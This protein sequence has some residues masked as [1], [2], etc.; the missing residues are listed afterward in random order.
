[1]TAAGE[2]GAA[3]VVS[4]EHPDVRLVD[5]TKK[6]DDVVAVDGLSLEIE[7]G[8]FFAMLG[9]SG[10]G[11]T[12]TLRMIGGFEQPTEGQIYL[13]DARGQRPSFRTSGTSTLSSS[14]TRSFRT[15]PSSRTSPSACVA[16]GFEGR[17]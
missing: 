9:P 17:H 13:G 4:G 14:R 3:Q 7:H 6:F 16:A 15:S 11:K 2:R 8:S 5:V 1:M 12:T 10:C